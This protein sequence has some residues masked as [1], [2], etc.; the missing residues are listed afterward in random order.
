[1]FNARAPQ[2]ATRHGDGESASGA[3]E[4]KIRTSEWTSARR[5]EKH[6]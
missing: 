6:I 3:F 1:M 2:V 5:I 4:K